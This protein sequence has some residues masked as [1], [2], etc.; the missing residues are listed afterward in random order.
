MSKKSA[1][2][3]LSGGLDSLVSLAAAIN[4]YD[5]MQCAGNYVKDCDDNH[6]NGCAGGYVGGYDIKLALT[7]DYGQRAAE[8]EIKASEEICRRYNIS[9]K[10]IKLPFLGEISNSALNSKDV[11]LEFETLGKESARAVW[12]PNRNGLFLNIAA[13][14]SD[15]FNYDAVIIGANKEEAETFPDNSKE[16]CKRMEDVFKY[17]TNSH[18]K[19]YA[20]LADLEKY[21]IINLAVKLNVDLKLLKS[22]Y[23]G[24]DEAQKS[25]KSAAFGHCGVCESCKRLKSAI[26]KSGNKDLIKL[27]F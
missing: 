27:L 12:V 6:T 10:V 15:A 22:C 23:N 18:P 4:G 3:L 26:L 19:V 16:F 17:S 7:F 1:V 14:F 21:E 24:T 25:A 20:P 11:K 5:S 8:D 13:S 9:H 2:I